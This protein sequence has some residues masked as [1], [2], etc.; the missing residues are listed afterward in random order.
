MKYTFKGRGYVSG[1]NKILQMS[2]FVFGALFF[3]L[4][5]NLHAAVAPT[6]NS[7]GSQTTS[8]LNISGPI[9]VQPGANISLGGSL[10]NASNV[11][12]EVGN[13]NLTLKYNTTHNVT[14]NVTGGFIANIT[15]PLT[16]QGAAGNFAL[17]NITVYTNSS[18]NHSK[19]LK[20]FVTNSSNVTFLVLT[21]KPPFAL[22]SNNTINVSYF[23]GSVALSGNKPLIKIFDSNG[24]ETT[25]VRAYNL[26]AA[27]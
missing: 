2:F 12:Q 27:T 11:S 15:A 18:D 3:A 21:Q 8:F 22:G 9:V 14:I 5:L 17:D 23:N 13:F 16:T 24:Q 7:N 4:A 20:F 25:L 1:S 19:V 10:I 26:S 6:S